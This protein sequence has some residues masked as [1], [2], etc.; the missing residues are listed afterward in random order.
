MKYFITILIGITIFSNTVFSQNVP[1]YVPTNGL[2]GWWPFNG[3]ANDISGN[4][5][6]GILNGSVLSTD[7]F[8]NNTSVETGQN[9]YITISNSPNISS[10]T[11]F[12]ISGWLYVNRFPNNQNLLSGVVTKW[13]GNKNCNN[14]SDDYAVFISS[15]KELVVVTRDFQMYPQNSLIGGN[16]DS[17]KWIHFTIVRSSNGAKLFVNGVLKDSNNIS[18]T[19]CNSTNPLYFGCDNGLGTPN[20]FLNG[21][22]DDIG[23]WNRALTESEIKG[24]Y[25]ANLCVDRISVTDTL[26]I[27]VN[28]TGYNPITFE[29]TLKV[30]PN[31]TK[32][33]ITIDNGNLSKM[34]GYSIKIMNSLGQQVFQSNINQQQFNIDI[35]AWGGNGI[36]FLQLIDNSGNIVDIRKILLQ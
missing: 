18:S 14:S 27:N 30:Y 23:I 20:R 35:T 8:G 16:I 9:K 29:N 26:V 11:E 17:L 1:S 33:K 10:P 32:D 7:R 31:P 24:L 15:S 5:N 21:L 25:N 36:Y 19:V 28:R 4:G 34:T 2:V 13:Y 12:S 3:N 6:N 22:V